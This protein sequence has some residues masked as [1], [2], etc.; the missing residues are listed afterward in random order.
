MNNDAPWPHA[1]PHWTLLP[2]TYLVTAGTFQRQRLFDTPAK[3]TL[4]THRLLDTAK[5]FGWQIKAWAVLANHYHILVDSP[6]GTGESLRVWLTNFHRTTAIALNQVD[7]TPGRRVWF[8]FWESHITHQ[9]SYLVRL[10][11]VNENAVHHKLVPLARMY[12]WCSAAWFETNAPAPFVASV[13]R[14]RLDR[15]K[16]RDDFD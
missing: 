3:L 4:V 2:G 11:Y 1:P 14:F 10:R 16:I 6:E 9:T 8:N 13:G 7:E 5:E 12:P 15:L